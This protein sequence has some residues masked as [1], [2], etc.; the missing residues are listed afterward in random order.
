MSDQEFNE[1]HIHEAADRIH[2]LT[3]VIDAVLMDHP[4]VIK[5]GL[6]ERLEGIQV[7]LA[8]CYAEIWK[9]G[10]GHGAQTN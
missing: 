4:A 2:C 7:E 3:L 1:G 10:V 5:A 9:L 6:Q 8:N